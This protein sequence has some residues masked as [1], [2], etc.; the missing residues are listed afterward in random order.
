MLK[1]FVESFGYYER[2]YENLEEL[3]SVIVVHG[4]SYYSNTRIIIEYHKPAH[5]HTVQ[6]GSVQ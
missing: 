1:V 3:K 2:V 5:N 4:F 6:I